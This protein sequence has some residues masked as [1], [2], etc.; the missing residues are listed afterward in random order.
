MALLD[1]YQNFAANDGTNPGYRM[2]YYA[3]QDSQSIA[4][5]TSTIT[6]RFGIGRPNSYTNYYYTNMSG[7]GV[8]LYYSTNNSTWNNLGFI[9]IPSTSNVYGSPTY[10]SKTFTITHN[11][12][13]TQSIYL[14]AIYTNGGSSWYGF[15][16]NNATYTSG[17]LA[18]TTIPRASSISVAQTFTISNTTG[19]LPFTI[20][21]QASF[22]HKVV[23]S[24]GSNS[25]TLNKT[26]AISSATSYTD[27]TNALML[28]KFSTQ[29]ATINFTLYTYSNSAL[30]DAYLIGTATTSCS[31]TVNTDNIK[32]SIS[33]AT[34][35]RNSGPLSIIVAGYSTASTTCTITNASGATT[36]SISWSI[37]RGSIASSSN[38]GATSNTLPASGSDYTFTFTA[39]VTDSRGGTATAT[40]ASATAKGYSAP[41][42]TLNAYRCVNTSNTAAD[43]AGSAAYYSRSAVT[44]TSLSGNTLTCS[45]KRDS[46]SITTAAT[47]S[48]GTVSLSTSSSMTFTAT[49]YDNVIGSSNAVTRT[50]TVNVAAYPLDLYQSGSTVGV[51][52]GAVASANLVD[53]NLPIR[54]KTTASTW[55]DGQKVLGNAALT[56]SDATNSNSFWPWIQHKN[57]N[58]AK[59]FALG[60]LGTRVY[61][62]GSA[63]SRTAND[64]DAGIYFDLSDGKIHGDLAGSSTSCSGNAATATTA[65]S[66][67]GNAATATTASSCSGNAATATSATTATKLGSSNVGS[68]KRPMYLSSGSPTQCNTLTSLKAENKSVG[69][70]WNISNAAANYNYLIIVGT[71]GSG[72][73]ITTKSTVYVPIPMLSTT[74]IGFGI[75]NESYGIRIECSLDSSNT[76][77]IIVKHAAQTQGSTGVLTNVYGGI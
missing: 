33:V 8:T 46:T 57:T 19:N 30:T 20:T 40:S 22:Y 51:G 2:E 4:N 73:G 50:V 32:P 23:W 21:P 58:S 53:S 55:L 69:E 29:T 70:S 26:T 27:V 10:V 37:S 72:Q 62:I 64:Y 3:T 11:T 6:F 43:G 68:A 17:A 1:T 65:S 28:P 16:V 76:N 77:N 52:L 13:G 71:P 14:R 54:A 61:L 49:A 75:A 59:M 36:S 42:F 9:D 18:L 38:S 47:A 48:S 44:Y 35:G 39:T 56:V 31:L 7:P 74:A 15:P 12:N 45:F 25:V 60:Q 24:I 67:S 63:T 66:C 41:S 5:N 34:P